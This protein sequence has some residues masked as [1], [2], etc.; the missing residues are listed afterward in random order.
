MQSV[1]NLKIKFRESFRPFA[2][3]VL[4]EK[5]S[6]YFEMKE[7]SPY[8]LLVADVK[9]GRQKVLS[10]EEQKLSGIDR[11]N[12][13]RSDIPAV[14]HINYSARIQTV[15]KE[16]NPKYYSLISKL[17]EKHGCAVIINTSF[18]VRGEPIVC[19]PEDAYKCF[20]RTNMDYLVLGNFILK[21]GEQKPLE[22]DTDWKKQFASD[23][24]KLAV[25]QTIIDE[26]G[27]I[28]GSKRDLKKFGLTVGI[29][30]IALAGVLFL[31]QKPSAIYCG[32]IGITLFFLALAAPIILKPLN[33]AWM[34]LSI[35]LGWI[36]TR[37]IL[38]LLFYIALTPLSLIAR[39]FGKDFINKKKRGPEDS[40]WQ[41]RE[42]RKFEKIDLERQF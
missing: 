1:M 19:T 28:K 41:K 30:L 36:M 33:K 27:K 16:T 23:K 18:N 11:L 24:T 39:I 38:I 42:E 32:I 2:P 25:T 20:M 12:V 21:K 34:A 15:C 31:K 37:I 7:E 4:E 9:K 8:M 26:I 17:N 6:D 5:V 14:T 13:V 35:I 22:N 10:T 3:S 40:Y 29:V